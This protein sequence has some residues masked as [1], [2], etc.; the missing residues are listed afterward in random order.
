[1]AT[2]IDSTYVDYFI[3]STER[4]ALSD[5]DS[6]VMTQLITSASAMV[7]SVL[8]N[9]GHDPDEISAGSEPEV[10]K[11]ATLGALL[12]MLYGRKGLAVPEQFLTQVRLL[13][14]IR[15]GEHTIPELTPD[16]GD[17][18]GGAEFT[19]NSEDSTD[20][21]PAVFNGVLRDYW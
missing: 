20:G 6:N 9:S 10:V 16:S 2:H 1:M 13:E 18:V 14:A 19:D 11:L 21:R 17:G 3:G 8:Q 15:V 12:P 7:D 4:S 5:A